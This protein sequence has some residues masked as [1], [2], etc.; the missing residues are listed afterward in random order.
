MIMGD[1][2]LGV[3]GQWIRWGRLD[4]AAN[5]KGLWIYM[6]APVVGAL[7]GATIYTG[8]KLKDEEDG[9]TLQGQGRSFRR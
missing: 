8:V 4:T 6:V 7:M 9:P 1:T 2:G 3:E 5:Y